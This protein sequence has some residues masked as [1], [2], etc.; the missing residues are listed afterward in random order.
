MSQETADRDNDPLVQPLKEADL[1]EQ[2]RPSKETPTGR[3]LPIAAFAVTAFA[4][5]AW[6]VPF[7][8]FAAVGLSDGNP[9]NPVRAALVATLAGVGVL[10]SIAG[11]MKKRWAVWGYIALGVSYQVAALLF[12]AWNPIVLAT[13]IGVAAVGLIALRDMEPSVS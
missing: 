2:T 5:S 3:T 7:L 1:V 9:L 4:N 11:W 8:T 10:F 12:N 13:Y 6:V